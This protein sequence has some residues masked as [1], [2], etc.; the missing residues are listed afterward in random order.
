MD[1]EGDPTY[2]RK[3]AEAFPQKANIS[4]GSPPYPLNAILRPFARIAGIA[5]RELATKTSATPIH[6]AWAK[7][8]TSPVQPR[9]I[10]I[11]RATMEGAAKGAGRRVGDLG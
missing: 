6:L 4:R 7:D 5:Y 10:E 9:F 1:D 11:A 3:C 2:R 8:A